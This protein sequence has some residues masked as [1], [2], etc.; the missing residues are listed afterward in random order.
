MLIKYV[1][2]ARCTPRQKTEVFDWF[3]KQLHAKVSHSISRGHWLWAPAET[4][5]QKFAAMLSCWLNHRQ[6][7]TQKPLKK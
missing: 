4:F 2:K 1:F 5:F 6:K 3:S 7:T